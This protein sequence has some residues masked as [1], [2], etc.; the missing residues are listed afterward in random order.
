MSCRLS[1]LWPGTMRGS[2]SSAATL[3]ELWPHGTY[4]P[5]PSPYRPSHRMVGLWSHTHAGIHIRRHTHILCALMHWYMHIHICR[6]RHRNSHTHRQTHMQIQTHRQRD[7]LWATVLVR[8]L[9]FQ[10]S[11]ADWCRWSHVLSAALSQVNSPKMG[12]SQ[13]HA[14]PS[15]K[16]STKQQELGRFHRHLTLVPFW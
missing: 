6:R 11:K 13:S 7:R 4:A 10:T 5:P 1:T 14:S 15:W 2:S 12:R 9:Q 8:F 16:W 3:M